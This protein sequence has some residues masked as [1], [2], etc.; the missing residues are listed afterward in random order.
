MQF[1]LYTLADTPPHFRSD[2]V[3]RASSIP[4]GAGGAVPLTYLRC[5]EMKMGTL[6]GVQLLV[7]TVEPMMA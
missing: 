5:L 7:A 6:S 4:D 1:G 3:L 2:C